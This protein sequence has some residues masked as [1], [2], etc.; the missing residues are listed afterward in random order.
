M[1]TIALALLAV[2]ALAAPRPA[3]AAE[4]LVVRA[5][6]VLE[7]PRRG[8]PAPRTVVVRDD[9]IVAVLPGA[10]AAIDAHRRDGDRLREV[11]FDA[12]HTVLPG[13]VD[14]HVHLTANPDRQWWQSAVVPVEASTINGVVNAA[15]TVRA[16]FTTVRDLGAPRQSAYALRDAIA[17]GEVIG[18]RVLAAGQ[19]ISIIGGHG[20]AGNNFRPEVAEAL[21]AGNTCTG[22][23]QCAE[24]V[25]RL[26]RAGADVIKLAATGGVL[27]QQNRGLDQ[28]FTDEELESIVRTAHALG[29]KVASHAHG[30]RGVAASAKAGVDS[31]EHGTFVD[32]DGIRAMKA[33]GAW[34]VPT[35]SPTIAYREHLG[36]G[37]YT[38]VVEAKIRER[39]EATGRNIRQ[40]HAA[41]IRIA[42]GTD[43]GVSDHGRNAEEFALMVREGR[44]TP[45]EALV[46]ATTGAAEL[47]GLADEIGTLAPGKSADL[48]AVP[49]DPLADVTVMER[50]V[51]VAA[52]GRI[53]REPG[54]G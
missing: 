17:R 1:R 54:E 28:H 15:K 35:L 18:P 27:S 29:L 8:D 33:G 5:E 36:T 50:V 37:R 24:R 48:I 10:D 53:V 51:F 43:A 45:R 12:S 2:H 30:P 26:S 42:F 32:A 3:A 52:R 20:D 13:L 21:D 44:M 14:S 31:V 38:P 9:R 41:G 7:D 16:G 46:A 11:R 19:M 49:G 23:V 39:L 6:R 22:P 47:L 40:A 4:V 25:R 34:L